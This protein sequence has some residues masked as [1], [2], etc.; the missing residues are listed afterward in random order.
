M[1]TFLFV[2]SF[3]SERLER[4]NIQSFNKWNKA[5]AMSKIRGVWNDDSMRELRENI[6]GQ[7]G[8]IK[9]LLTAFSA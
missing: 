2:F 3:L 4:L 5:T 6:R 8:A 9:L 7:V 1:G